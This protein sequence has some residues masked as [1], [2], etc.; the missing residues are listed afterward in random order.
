MVKLSQSD[1]QMHKNTAVKIAICMSAESRK[2]LPLLNVT[3]AEG[4]HFSASTQQFSL[5]MV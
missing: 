5:T 1:R 2:S 3:C 4:Q